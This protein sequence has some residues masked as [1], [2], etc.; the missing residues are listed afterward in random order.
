MKIAER[1]GKL[2]P[3]GLVASHIF[4]PIEDAFVR[5]LQDAPRTIAARAS[6][7]V[8]GGESLEDIEKIVRGI[9]SQ[10]VRGVKS[11]SQKALRN[12]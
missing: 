3:R 1:A 10:Q 2:I 4:G 5:M 6:S 11:R 12:A 7:A 8:K 9:L